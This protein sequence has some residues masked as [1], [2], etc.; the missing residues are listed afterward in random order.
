MRS[1]KDRHR[2]AEQGSARR[3]A[4]AGLL[5]CAL[6]SACAVASACAFLVAASMA[7]AHAADPAIRSISVVGAKRLSPEA[8]I[9]TAGFSTGATYTDAKAAAAIQALYAT[10]NLS[11][12]SIKLEGATLVIAIAEA[13]LVGS[14]KIEGNSAV[15]TKTLEAALPLKANAPYSAAK[16]QAAQRALET[17]YARRGRS[18]ARM[19]SS[20]STNPQGLVDV[21]ITVS[22]STVDKVAD[23]RF[24]GARAFTGKDLAAVIKTAPSSWLDVLKSDAFYDPERLDID[25]A[26]LL[27]FYRDNG[28]SDAKII[29]AAGVYDAAKGGHI[30]TFTIEEGPRY[31]VSGQRIESAVSGVTEKDLAGNLGTETGEPVNATR[32]EKTSR[33]MTL[34]LLK[35]GHAFANVKAKIERDPTAKTATVVYRV[36]EIAH[37][38]VGKIVV[39]GNTRTDE[40]VI[41]R[42]MKLQEGDAAHPLTIERA[43]NRIRALGL[44]K[45]VKVEPKMTAGASVVD[46]IVQVEEDETQ[47]LGFGIGLSQNEG[48]VGDVSYE[49]RNL[50]GRGQRAKLKLA[51]SLKR[52]DA[53]AG[54]TEPNLMG[55]DL[56][57]GFDLFYKD[58]DRSAEQSFKS[59]R[60][61]GDVRLGYALTDEWSGEVRYTLSEST[62]YDVGEAASAAIKEAALGTDTN[63]FITSSLG[64]SLTYDTRDDKR[65]PMSGVMLSLG[66][67]FAGIGGDVRFIKSTADLRVY[68]PLTDA[69]TLANRATGG[70]IT[71]WGG[72]DV[73]LL[74]TFTRGGD[75]VRGFAASGIGPRDTASLNA[76]ALGGTTFAGISTALQFSLPF[77][78]KEAGLRAEVFADAGSLFGATAAASALP[79]TQGS[80]AALRSSVGAGL[81]WDS[82]IGPLRADY[83][84]PVAKQ[85]FDK[86]QPFSFGI[87]GF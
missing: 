6:V 70:I 76:D 71:G 74:D 23:I 15:D 45:S 1:P 24:E 20:A 16:V 87:G 33:A 80:A 79:G 5:A 29:A 56:A 46:L 4:L 7:T 32:I 53:E 82:P 19:T 67:D 37:V 40:H 42:A 75:L 14:I 68:T 61:G 69:I 26:L 55:S 43:T 83:A 49:E 27:K 86:T 12:A 85:P 48:I 30:V 52:L 3:G 28:Y 47:N 66:Q 64:Y 36:D 77:V 25:R 62:L 78:P 18:T 13:P 65:I 21:V 35:D 81:I 73:R 38:T 34:A 39:T 54:F 11:D 41:R 2:R 51:G 8:V 59:R 57:A 10:G 22:E 9:A 63:S 44:F 31:T 58:L 50:M 17:L 72:Q 84:I 60:I